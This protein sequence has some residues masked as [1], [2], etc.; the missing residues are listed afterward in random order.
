MSKAPEIIIAHK[1]FEFTTECNIISDTQHGFRPSHST[2][3]QLLKVNSL[4][5]TKVNA[6]HLAIVTF[7]EIKRAYDSVWPGTRA[8]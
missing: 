7:L 4:L 8:S 1:I 5:N 3:T 2:H 6:E